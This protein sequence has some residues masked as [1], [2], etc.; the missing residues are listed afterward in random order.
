MTISS[1]IPIRDLARF[2]GRAVSTTATAARVVA[3]VADAVSSETGALP[4]M[5]IRELQDAVTQLEM[6]STLVAQALQKVLADEVEDDERVDLIARRVDQH[7]DAL[8]AVHDRLENLAGKFHALDIAQLADRQRLGRAEDSIAAG[9]D[10]QKLLQNRIRELESNPAWESR[11]RELE[12]FVEGLPQWPAD[13][14]EPPAIAPVQPAR[15]DDDGA[16]PEPPRASCGA[17]VMHEGE[18]AGLCDGP[19]PCPEHGESYPF[20]LPTSAGG[21]P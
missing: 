11:V 16:Q 14:P 9:L 2:L 18:C 1:K 7:N 19:F 4:P 13:T 3:G 8:S 12:A 5:K 10:W 6:D 15:V 20:T 17:P 21:T